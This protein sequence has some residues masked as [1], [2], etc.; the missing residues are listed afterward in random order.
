MFLNMIPP[1]IISRGLC[2]GANQH[3]FGMFV[4]TMICRWSSLTNKMLGCLVVCFELLRQVG[5]FQVWKMLPCTRMKTQWNASF[6]KKRIFTSHLQNKCRTTIF[7]DPNQLLWK[8]NRSRARQ[9]SNS[10]DQLSPYFRVF[11]LHTIYRLPNVITVISDVPFNR[12]A[13]SCEASHRMSRKIRIRSKIFNRTRENWKVRPFSSRCLLG[14]VNNVIV[15]YNPMQ[16]EAERQSKN[17]WSHCNCR[18]HV[19]CPCYFVCL[20]VFF[21]SKYIIFQYCL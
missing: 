21:R 13:R 9:R 4:A 12:I 14:L 20:C 6:L 16:F 15:I 11:V 19:T 3:T 17:V 5:R 8:H 1:P 2:F 7:S 18:D 10:Q